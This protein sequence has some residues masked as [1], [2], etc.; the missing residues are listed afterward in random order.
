MNRSR[1]R[2]IKKQVMPNEKLE[3]QIFIVVILKQGGK[4]YLRED[5][6][7]C[8]DSEDAVKKAWLSRQKE[9]RPDAT[10]IFALLNYKDRT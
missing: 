5:P 7:A 9:V 10:L 8:F 1:I 4:Y 3:Q 2:S 6:N